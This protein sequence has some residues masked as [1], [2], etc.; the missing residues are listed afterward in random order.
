ME[1]VA[2]VSGQPEE[3]EQGA[4]LLRTE[5]GLGGDGLRR[6]GRG[7]AQ[8]ELESLIG[9][10]HLVNPLSCSVPRVRVGVGGSSVQH[11][12]DLVLNAQPETSSKFHHK[13]LGIRVFCV[14]DQGLEVV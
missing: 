14:G 5:V 6:C 2:E 9:K 10:A 1:R 8:H 12:G 4:V 7:G 3:A 11:G 13:C